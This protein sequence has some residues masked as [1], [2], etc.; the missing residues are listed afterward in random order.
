MKIKDYSNLPSVTIA[1]IVDENSI[2]TRGILAFK[3]YDSYE[4]DKLPEPH[5]EW[6]E[7]CYESEHTLVYICKN[8][9]WYFTYDKRYDE[10]HTLIYTDEY[11]ANSIDQMIDII[12]Q[13]FVQFN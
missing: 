6:L 11:Y 8:T 2:D 3:E 10:Y 9:G 5:S 13:N 12:D 7:G 4:M 1:D